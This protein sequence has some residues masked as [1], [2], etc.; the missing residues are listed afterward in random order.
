MRSAPKQGDNVTAAGDLGRVTA[1]LYSRLTTSIRSLE[2]IIPI[3]QRLLSIVSNGSGL[4]LWVW[5]QVGTQQLRNWRSGASIHLNCLFGYCSMEIS[6]PVL[7]GRVVTGL[8]SGSVCR[9]IECSCFCCLIRVFDHNHSFT[10][11]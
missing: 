11:Q 8:S 1:I 7:I 3:H 10:I 5:V 2:I 6:Q 4:S 9:F